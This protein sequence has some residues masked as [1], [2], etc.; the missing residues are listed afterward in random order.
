MA[1][2]TNATFTLKFTVE[3]TCFEEGMPQKLA[4]AVSSIWY[5]GASKLI[6]SP[7]YL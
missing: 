4:A 3:F 5:H 6:V 1:V 2:T 7:G